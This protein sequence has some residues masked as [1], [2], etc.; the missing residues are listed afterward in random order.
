MFKRPGAMDHKN[1]NKKVPGLESPKPR[2][3]IPRGT[4]V[5]VVLPVFNRPAMVARALRSVLNQSFQ[6]YIVWAVDDGSTNGTLR[7]LKEQQSLF[8]AGQMRIISLPRNR[9]VSFARNMGIRAGQAPYLAFLD[10]DDEWTAEKLTRQVE[11]A[12][13]Q[14]E[15]H[16]IHTEEVWIRRGVRVNPKKKH[17]KKGGRIFKESLPLCCISP[18]SVMVQR[19]FLNRIGLFRE[20][21]PVCE[22][23]E[24]WLRVTAQTK[25][26]FIEEPLTVKYGGHEDQLSKKHDI[27]DEWRVRALAGHLKSSFINEEE[28]QSLKEVL[29]KKCQI[30]LNGYQKHNNRTNEK[31]IQQI[32]QQ[33][34][35][36]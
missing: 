17:Q 2:V 32:Y 3:A 7:T 18:S 34:L 20:D 1:S 24:L 16:F 13:V 22:D 33:S 35:Q 5:D 27:M 10:S 29:Q 19:E 23:Y 30:L 11:W 28:R 9:G 4:R 21:F 12:K 25:V 26:G 36:N 14:T 15:R 31:E 6:D 8:P